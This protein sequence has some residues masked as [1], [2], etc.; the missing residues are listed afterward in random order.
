MTRVAALRRGTIAALLILIADQVSKWWMLREVFGLEG[1]IAAGVRA[2]GM[3]VTG[4]LNFTLVWN[5]GVSFGLFG[6]GSD[7]QR[8]A[9][10]VFAVV[11]CIA[12]VVWMARGER[13]LTVLG[14]AAIIG[15]ALG[16][17]IDRVRFGAVADFLDFHAFGTHFWVFNIADAGITLGV[18]AIVVDSIVGGG[19]SAAPRQI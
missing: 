13:W 5:F 11:V 8:W 7:W 19:K 15:G 10:T 14:L 3:E 4:F 2:P 1:P 17:A 12:L 6:S 16:N 18:I 9:L